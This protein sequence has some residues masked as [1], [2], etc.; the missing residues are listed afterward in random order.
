MDRHTSKQ[1]KAPRQGKEPI[2]GKAFRQG[3]ATI[4]KARHLYNSPRQGTYT[5]HLGKASR[6]VKVKAT[7]QGKARQGNLGSEGKGT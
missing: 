3:K 7:R 5:R 1:G 2:Q 6:E 4:G